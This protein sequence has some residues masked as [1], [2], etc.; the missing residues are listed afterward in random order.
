MVP[1]RLWVDALVRRAQVA[2]A[3]AIAVV[4]GDAERGDVLVKVLDRKGE[5]QLFERAP[6]PDR[7]AERFIGWPADAR[8]S[9]ER[10]DER[11]DRR[12]RTDPDLW[13]VEIQ[14]GRG[15]SFLPGTEED[16]D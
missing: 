5:A 2:G 7:E 4:R 14:D 10:V 3:F 15:R 12:L 1:T 9:E 11:I 6:A 16:A 13:V 8:T